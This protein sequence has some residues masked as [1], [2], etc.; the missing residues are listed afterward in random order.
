MADIMPQI[1]WGRLAFGNVD[2]AGIFKNG[3]IE[4][5]K[6]KTWSLL[7]KTAV[8]K[9]FVLSSGC[10]VPPGTPIENVEAFYDTLKRFNSEVLMEYSA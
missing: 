7:E 10:D 9:N 3:T 8:Y 1:P 4:Q 6:E 5:V 2:P